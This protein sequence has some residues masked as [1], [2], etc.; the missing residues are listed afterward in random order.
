MAYR[1]VRMRRLA[2]PGAHLTVMDTGGDGTALVMLHT[3]PTDWREWRLVVNALPSGTRVVAIDWRGSGQSACPRSGYSTR[4]RVEDLIAVLDALDLA[5]VDLVS[6]GW[7][8]WAGFFATVRYPE[9][10]RRHIAM[11]MAH[12]WVSRATALSQGWRYW[13]TALWEYPLVGRFVL[14]R[15]RWFTRWTLR[16]WARTAVPD[17]GALVADYAEAMGAP[18]VA[19]AGEKLHSSFVLRD[20]P[21][22]ASGR[23]RRLALEV[24]TLVLVGEK[25]PVVPPRLV[26]SGARPERMVVEVVAS[27]G[28]LLPEEVPGLVAARCQEWLA[29]ERPVEPA[30][31]AWRP[32]CRRLG[33]QRIAERP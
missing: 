15:C 11:S 32:P 23:L 26:A 29:A 4:Q 1:S 14:R 10:F 3:F 21:L 30:V 25:D 7:G 2:V 24:P 20:I 17:G 5:R 22:L 6:H 18:G 13:H 16:R 12:P 33:G 27:A 8:S 9:R 31:E 28:H 19:R